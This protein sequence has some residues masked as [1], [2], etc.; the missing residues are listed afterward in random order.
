MHRAWLGTETDLVRNKQPTCFF[1]F[2]LKKQKSNTQTFI[3]ITSSGRFKLLHR[4]YHN[5][6]LTN[7]TLFQTQF[8]IDFFFSPQKMFT[9]RILRTV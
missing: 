2:I 3:I 1:F 8:R 5:A 4:T 7:T 6:I 9:V